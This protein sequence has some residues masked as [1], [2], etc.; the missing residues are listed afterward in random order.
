MSDNPSNDTIHDIFVNAARHLIELMDGGASVYVLKLHSDAEPA[1][2]D[3]S[4]R[5]E[6]LAITRFLLRHLLIAV[7]DFR[8]ER[9]AAETIADDLIGIIAE[10]LIR[11]TIEDDE[12]SW[13]EEYYD[14]IDNRGNSFGRIEEP[15]TLR[16]VAGLPPLLPPPTNDIPP[17]E[18]LFDND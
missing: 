10:D 6:L 16:D 15:S 3:L 1:A 12:E 7:Q 18:G 14:R 9:D 2:F 11:E 17:P 8:E 4:K 13:Y 5:D